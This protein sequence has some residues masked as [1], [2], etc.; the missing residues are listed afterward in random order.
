MKIYIYY[1]DFQKELDIDVNEKIGNIQEKLLNFCNLIIYNIEY[2]EL[3]LN[4]NKKYIL[5]S[6]DLP[7]DNILKNIINVDNIVNFRLYERKRDNLGNVIKNNYIID[8]YV[9]WYSESLQENNFNFSFI[10][11]LNERN[12]IRY[13]ISNI[14]NN[15]F[16]LSNIEKDNVEQDIIMQDNIEQ[17]TNEQDMEIQNTQNTE[18]QNIETQNT[19]DQEKI[20]EENSLENIIH[21][22]DNYFKNYNNTEIN[23]N[24]LIEEDNFLLDNEYTY[25][26][27]PDL[28]NITY[29]LPSIFNYLEDNIIIALNDEEFNNLD[30]I[31]YK[32][33]SLYIE[34]TNKECLICLDNF[35]END[36]I[37]KIKCNHIFHTN[38]I[39]QWLCK[40]S[41]K[42]PIC[43]IEVS[44]GSPINI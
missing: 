42:C 35:V 18:T 32:E 43:R 1:N 37:I 25:N 5:G 20:I 23:N 17:D 28:I 33:D 26:D 21:T 2:T 4:N 13:P 27:I 9:K 8:N 41:N 39:K 11:L 3:L 22:I 30:K 36:E 19:T 14:L 34:N 24:E 6:D 10:P 38:C 40:E 12:I 44:K 16:H 7:Y 15:I 29:E 31:K